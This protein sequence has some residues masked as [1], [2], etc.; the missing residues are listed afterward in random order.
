[1]SEQYFSQYNSPNIVIEPTVIVCKPPSPKRPKVDKILQ[2]QSPE[3]LDISFLD[4]LNIDEIVACLKKSE[5]NQHCL[6]NTNVVNKNDLNMKFGTITNLKFIESETCIIENMEEN[7][8]SNNT[9]CEKICKLHSLSSFNTEDSD[10]IKSENKTIN[11]IKIIKNFKKSSEYTE[12]N[13][14]AIKGELNSSLSFKFIE[15]TKAELKKSDINNF[16]DDSDNYMR[17]KVNVDLVSNDCPKTTTYT[18][19]E[20]K[21]KSMNTVKCKELNNSQNTT[22]PVQNDKPNKSIVKNKYIEAEPIKINENKKSSCI[23][24]VVLNKTDV[25]LSHNL[26]K[27][28]FKCLHEK[29]SVLSIIHYGRF[30]KIFK[31]KDSAGKEYALKMLSF[32][33]Y[34]YSRGLHQ[35]KM[36][37]SIQCDIPKDNLFCVYL[38]E[39]FVINGYWCFVMDFY[40]QNLRQVLS[41]SSKPLDIHTVQD[42]ARQLVSAVTLLRNNNI[43]H[44]DINPNHI[45][46]NCSN[47]K[48]KLCGFD[49]AYYIESAIISPNLGTCSYR[50]PE[51]ILGYS[52]GFSIDVWSTALVLHEMA[53][54][55]KLFLGY[56]N[57]D[58][59]YKQMSILGNIPHEMINM[60]YYSINYFVGY[61][62]KRNFG[63][64]NEVCVV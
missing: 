15:H 7:A 59:L 41:N 40:P 49:N 45:L 25:L 50:A 34:K 43:V 47:D 6:E 13:V 23:K 20:T 38:H 29:H 14:L 32:S 11:D 53:T 5:E 3:H 2:D 4:D 64:G 52:A 12:K 44:S 24:S 48:L 17:I 54:G 31:C 22:L 21:I 16:N 56:I 30:S 58:I 36:L 37:K 39:S 35:Q 42:L 9:E 57:S 51:V 28:L 10:K 63:V 62:F 33:T 18:K 60:S 55:R 26:E 19:S 8:I 27:Y 61:T 1:M 46:L